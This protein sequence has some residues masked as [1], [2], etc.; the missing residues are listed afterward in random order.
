MQKRSI[1]AFVAPHLLI[2]I[3][4]FY[5]HVQRP[6]HIRKAIWHAVVGRRTFKN[7]KTG[8]TSWGNKIK[9]NFNY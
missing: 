1:S 8:L 5:K 4:D 2:H 7:Y 6:K 9:V 3:H